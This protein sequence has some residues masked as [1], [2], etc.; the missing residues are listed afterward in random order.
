MANEATGAG[1][2]AAQMTTLD[3]ILIDGKMARDDSQKKYAKDLIGEF[4]N[5]VIG[6]GMV[7]SHDTFASI[8]DRIAQIDELIGKQLNEVMHAPEFQQL[9]ASWRGLN[10]LVSKTETSKRMKIRL[11]NITKKELLSDLEKATEFDQSDFFKK[12]YEE[13]YGTF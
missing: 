4:V 12:I 7:V 11:L 13:E 10:F 5:Q 1:A 6:E 3:K 9:E 2:A 8:N